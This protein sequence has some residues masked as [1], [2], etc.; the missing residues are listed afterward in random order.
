MA[1]RNIDHRLAWLCSF[2]EI[3]RCAPN[4]IEFIEVFRHASWLL[5]GIQEHRLLHIAEET[6]LSLIALSNSWRPLI[7]LVNTSK[8]IL[9]GA[10]GLPNGWPMMEI[11]FVNYAIGMPAGSDCSSLVSYLVCFV[12]HN[13]CL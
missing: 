11:A 5:L 9:L 12:L 13:V 8:D 4:L 7:P 3:S 2:V 10:T 1:G 6:R